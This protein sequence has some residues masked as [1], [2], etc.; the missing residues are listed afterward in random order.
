VAAAAIN[1]WA[2][3][4]PSVHLGGEGCRIRNDARPDGG[5]GT[6]PSLNPRMQQ[7]GPIQRRWV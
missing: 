7:D 4:V 3:I 1:V 5:S 2:G 6:D